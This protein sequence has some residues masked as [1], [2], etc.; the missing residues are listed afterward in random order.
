MHSTFSA[1]PPPSPERKPR[2]GP[3]WQASPQSLTITST[4]RPRRAGNHPAALRRQHCAPG[5]RPLASRV[6]RAVCQRAFHF[7]VHQLTAHSSQHTPSHLAALSPTSRG[8][9]LRTATPGIR[10]ESPA[11]SVQREQQGRLTR[12]IA[13]AAGE[14][15]LHACPIQPPPPPVRYSLP[16][17]ACPI[18]P[19]HPPCPIW[20]G[21]SCPSPCPMR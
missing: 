17:P 12:L 20:V 21:A 13:D 4:D 8:S 7:A 2:P 15:C 10:D 3:P 19:P 18:Q 14:S 6:E 9:E 5:I 11:S 1:R 16:P